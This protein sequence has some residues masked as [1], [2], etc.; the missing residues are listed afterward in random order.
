[1]NYAALLDVLARQAEVLESLR[2]LLEIERQVLVQ[3]DPHR[4]P[5]LTYRKSL[6]QQELQFLEDKRLAICAGEKTLKNIIE[7]S[8]AAYKEKLRQLGERLLPLAEDAVSANRLNA[9]LLRQSLD[10]INRLAST[11]AQPESLGGGRLRVL[12][13]TA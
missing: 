11:L 3:N 10:Y 12:D 1:M 9:L 7:H 2:S 8:P 13:E 5:D 4:L 6:L